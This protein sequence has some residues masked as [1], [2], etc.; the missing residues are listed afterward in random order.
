MGLT[1][2]LQ[3]PRLCSETLY[4]IFFIF[5]YLKSWYNK[6]ERAAN[7]LFYKGVL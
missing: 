7:I 6:K 1:P 2:H 5:W 3:K 4:T